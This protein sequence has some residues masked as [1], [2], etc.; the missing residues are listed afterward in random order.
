MNSAPRGI[1]A[2][3]VLPGEVPLQYYLYTPHSRAPR[4][5]VVCVHGISRNAY[6]YAA[7]L[8]PLAE[9][10]GLALV[11]PLF[12]DPL[13]RGYQRLGWDAGSVRADL[14]LTQMVEAAARLVDVPGDD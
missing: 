8:W 9:Y 7:T 11:A 5:L 2:E 3:L 10:W 1:I 13:F 14:T 6:E 4:V 12:G